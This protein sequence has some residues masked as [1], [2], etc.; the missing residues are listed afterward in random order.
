[1]YATQICPQWWKTGPFQPWLTGYRAFLA[2][3]VPRQ[4]QAETTQNAPLKMQG[5]NL[6]GYHSTA[7]MKAVRKYLQSIREVYGAHPDYAG[8]WE[9]PG[10]PPAP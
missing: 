9:H 8:R 3:D 7:K 2:A 5:V 6:D 1:V 10:L 4:E